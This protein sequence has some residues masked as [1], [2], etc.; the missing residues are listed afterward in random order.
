MALDTAMM[1]RIATCVQLD[2]IQV[3]ELIVVMTVH[4]DN[5]WIIPAR[6]VAI[7]VHPEA[8]ILMRGI[9]VVIRPQQVRITWFN[10]T[11]AHRIETVS[12]GYYAPY[13]GQINCC[14]YYCGP[15]YYS[16]SGR[17]GCDQAPPG[18]YVAGYYSGGYNWCDVGTYSSNWASTTCYQCSPGS[19]APYTGMTSCYGCPSGQYQPF[20]GYSYCYSCP[21][22]QYQLSTGMAN[23][24]AA[25]SGGLLVLCYLYCCM[26]VY[27]GFFISDKGRKKITDKFDIMISK[28]ITRPLSAR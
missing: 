20:Y 6:V 26:C 3:E 25:P 7:L 14:D 2:N 24:L 11:P 8:L 16:G 4:R 10:P 15:G 13:Y 28:D 18:A 23:C 1:G 9:L 17:S 27:F 5:T 22:G 12:V 21:V 19:Y